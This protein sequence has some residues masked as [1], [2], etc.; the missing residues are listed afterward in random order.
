MDRWRRRPPPGRP[1]R[2]RPAGADTHPRPPALAP[3]G[4]PAPGFP[5]SRLIGSD[6]VDGAS[7]DNGPER[8]SLTFN[9]SLTPGF[10]TV[11]VVGPDGLRYESGDGA[12][13]GP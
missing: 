5:H 2:R 3:L 13:A 11:T 9:E 12:L 1:P 4:G 8:V 7:L 10:N 6:P